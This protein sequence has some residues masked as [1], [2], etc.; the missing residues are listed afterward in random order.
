MSEDIIVIVYFLYS[1]LQAPLSALLLENF[2]K[3]DSDWV[4]GENGILVL[5]PHPSKERKEK[6]GKD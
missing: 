4:G 6:K 1:L 5:F 2:E 3:E